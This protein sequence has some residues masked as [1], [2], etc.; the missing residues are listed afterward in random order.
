MKYH[1]NTFTHASGLVLFWQARVT[2]SCTA[3][4]AW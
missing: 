2:S 4:N 3:Q 1:G